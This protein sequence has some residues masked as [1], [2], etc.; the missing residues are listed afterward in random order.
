MAVDGETETEM[1]GAG[2]TVMVELADLV[3]SAI[4][5]ARRVTVAGVGTVVGAV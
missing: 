4:D 3:E 2:A 5:V 1:D